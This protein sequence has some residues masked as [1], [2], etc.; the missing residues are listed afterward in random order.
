MAAQVKHG[1]ASRGFWNEPAL[2]TGH[3]RALTPSKHPLDFKTLFTGPPI[4]LFLQHAALRHRH[5]ARP[6]PASSRQPHCHHRGSRLHAVIP[7][8]QG[9]EQPRAVQG[10]SS[11]SSHVLV[12]L[13]KAPIACLVI[14]RSLSCCA[15]LMPGLPALHQRCPSDRCLRAH[16]DRQCCCRDQALPMR[17]TAE[18]R[19]GCCRLEKCQDRAGGAKSRLITMPLPP[20]LPPHHHRRSTASQS[21]SPWPPSLPRLCP[22][23][24]RP[25]PA[26]CPASSKR[27]HCCSTPCFGSQQRASESQV[28][29]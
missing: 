23:P 28:R 15:A 8:S 7:Q 4:R 29:A 3:H 2:W 22:C 13:A 14:T 5:R 20:P 27:R 6:S 24:T 21:A 11:A 12:L 26:L 17:H 10:E 25:A 9:V 18:Q 1:L 16:P 19:G